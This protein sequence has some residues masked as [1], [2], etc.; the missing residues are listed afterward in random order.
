M[1]KKSITINNKEIMKLLKEL[2]KNIGKLS[3]LGIQITF[4]LFKEFVNKFRSYR[5]N[6]QY[7]NCSNCIFNKKH[8]HEN[9]TTRSKTTRK[10]EITF[11]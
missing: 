9:R 3:L 8:K 2:L 6:E 1:T 11:I 5:K 10:S 4:Y 7:W